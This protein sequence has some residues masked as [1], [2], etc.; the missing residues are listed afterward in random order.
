M[1][2]Q[3]MDVV[4]DT[5]LDMKKARELRSLKQSLCSM[6]LVKYGR[7]CPIEVMLRQ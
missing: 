5:A 1:H 3:A 7:D 6:S 2:F 4:E